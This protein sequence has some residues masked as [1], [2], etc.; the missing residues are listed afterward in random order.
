M[1]KTIKYFFMEMLKNFPRQFLFLLFLLLIESLV[2]AS[3]VL[4]IVP[5]ADYLLDSNLNNPSKITKVAIK[6]LAT[7]NFEPNYFIF[8]TI[9][10]LTNIIR[11]FFDLSIQYF[12]LKIKYSIIKTLTANLFYR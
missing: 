3:S 7:F 6:I 4:T 1:N 5:L 10:I 12:T 11:S 2:L 8:G 9:F